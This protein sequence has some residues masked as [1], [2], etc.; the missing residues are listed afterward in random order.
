MAS[1]KQIEANRLNALKSTGPRTSEGKSTS[2][3]NA[4]KHGIFAEAR[5]LIGEDKTAFEALRDD[6]LDRFHPSGPA[7]ASPC[8]QNARR[9]PHPPFLVSG[10][11]PKT[12]SHHLERA[13]G[14][15]HQ[16]LSLAH[17]PRPRLQ[18]ARISAAP[19]QFH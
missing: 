16:P 3:L 8:E 11:L 15:S 14:R 13:P 1:I 9:Q 7:E 17:G 4:F 2:R 5:T 10:P 18:R 12:R 6:Y 19:H